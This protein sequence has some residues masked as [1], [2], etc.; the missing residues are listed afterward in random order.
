MVLVDYIAIAAYL[1]FILFIGFFVS[2]FQ[3]GGKDYFAGGNKIPWWISGISLYMTN[4]SA[5]TFIG[6]AG[7]VY[8]SGY[9]AMFG[10][11]GTPIA[12]I[13]AGFIV[14]GLWRRTRSISPVEYAQTRY[15]VTSQQTIGMALSFCHTLTCAAQLL[16]VSVITSCCCGVDIELIIL[17]IGIV[18]ILYTYFGGMWAVSIADVVQ[19]AI[20]IAITA[21]VTP[22]SLSL[23]DGGLSGLIAK[24][25][26]L[27]L[28]NTIGSTNY[29]IH[30]I[31][32]GFIATTIGVASGMGPRF[33][34]VVDEKAAKKV[35]IL[36]GLLFLTFPLLFF[37]PPLVGRAIW[38]ELGDIPKAVGALGNKPPQELVFIAIVNKVLPVGLLGVFVAAMLAAT[39]DGLSA[40][41]NFISSI[42]S[43]DVYKGLIKHNAS[44]ENILKVGRIST[45]VVGLIVTGLALAYHRFGSD[46][47]GIMARVIA[48]FAAPAGV[49]IAF[50]LLVKKLPRWSALASFIWGLIASI[51]A[52]LILNWNKW[53]LG[54]QV[55]LSLG[56]SIFILVF[57]YQIGKWYKNNK[58]MLFIFSVFSAVMFAFFLNLGT[59]EPLT[60]SQKISVGV[61]SLIIGVSAWVFGYLFSMETEAEKEMVA[62]FFKKLA[63]PIDVATEVIGRGVQERSAFFLVGIISTL[64]GGVIAVS[65]AVLLI[66][67]TAKYS[68]AAAFLGTAGVLILIGLPIFFF[69]RRYRPETEETKP[70][71]TKE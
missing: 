39:M 25:P 4:F 55:Y 49:P 63:T 54:Y 1:V 57:A 6:T 2:R 23:V 21:V 18:V 61:F 36:A 44:D 46:I 5:Y 20:L 22:L 30:W 62:D 26:P 34:S 32:S 33:Y 7:L 37:I 53:S 52:Q 66:I 50:G 65:Y 68:D 15:N 19:F 35:G 45:L 59:M 67:G 70:A 17:T 29:D 58:I 51:V 10:S 41:Y 11:I 13:L 3:K 40:F 14:G 69:G 71:D 16:A 56:A 9:Y 48:I 38:P 12:Y 28:D 24:I 43:R 42:V 64:F 27:K 31:I 8:L 60:H 47:L